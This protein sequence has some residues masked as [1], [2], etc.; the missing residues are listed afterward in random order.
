MPYFILPVI[1]DKYLPEDINLT[2]NIVDSVKKSMPS[3][4]ILS[5][6]I[7]TVHESKIKNLIE[8]VNNKSQDRFY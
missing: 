7:Y 1:T 3:E 5:T 4:Y 6:E 2:S 8:F